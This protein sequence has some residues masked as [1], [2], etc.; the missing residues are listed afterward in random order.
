VKH[1]AALM[2]SQM[3]NI[4]TSRIDG[5]DEP[6]EE[7]VAASDNLAERNSDTERKMESPNYCSS[8]AMDEDDGSEFFL[9]LIC[10]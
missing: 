5:I 9:C 8:I 10:L 7:D 3:G 6:R 1:S 2:D 4:G